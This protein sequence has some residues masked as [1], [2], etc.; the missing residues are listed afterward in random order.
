M[1]TAP[2][3]AANTPTLAQSFALAWAAT[4]DAF[5][6]STNAAATAYATQSGT[7]ASSVAT[8]ETQVGLFD[9]SGASGIGQQLADAIKSALWRVTLILSLILGIV[10][11]AY[12]IVRKAL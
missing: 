5:A 8:A 4:T 2:T 10:F 6:L 9:L 7:D 3:T 11:F 1:A 12:L